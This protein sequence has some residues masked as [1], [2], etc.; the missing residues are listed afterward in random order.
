MGANLKTGGGIHY[1][2]V[3]MVAFGFV[4]CGSIGSLT[5]LSGL[6][7]YPVSTDLGCDLS[8]LTLYMTITMVVLALSMPLVGN[9]LTRVK[10]QRILTGAAILEVGSLVAMSQL[11]EAWMWYIAGAAS[12]LGLA[13]TS[14]VTITPTIGNWFHRKTGFA[15]G[16]VWAI[17]SVYDAAVSPILNNVIAACGWRTGYLA[18]AAISALMLF[19]SAIF[20]IRYRPQEKGL[21]PYGYDPDAARAHQRADLGSGVPWKAAVRSAPFVLC[22]FLVMLCQMTACMNQVFPTYAE[23][24][25]LGA[26]VGSLMVSAASICDVFLNPMAGATGDK[27]GITKS[28]VLWTGI[29]MVS[30]VILI[31]GMGSPV[32]SCIGAGINDAMYAICGVGY[33]MFALT[34]FGMRDFERIY[35]RMACVGCLVASLGVPLMMFIYESTGSFTNVF[36]FCILVDAVIIGLVLLAVKTSRTLTW[37]DGEADAPAGAAEAHAAKADAPATEA[38]T[39][40][41]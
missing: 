10:I 13:A 27:F 39:Y 21:L 28:M 26:A 38:K 24:V 12:G 20:L 1:A 25:G 41:Q 11:T 32:L 31:F 29:T 36:L 4:M 3:V 17:Q 2:W 8:T 35:S 37:V 16:M 18:L 6:F 40:C 14:T 9:L 15:I 34:L 5:V 33:S 23:V 22:V 7:F 19:P 30:F